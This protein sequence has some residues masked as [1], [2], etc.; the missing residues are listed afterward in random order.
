MNKKEYNEYLET[1]VYRGI[2]SPD[3][4]IYKKLIMR[5]STRHFNPSRRAVFLLR[6]M[7]YYRSRG[8]LWWWYAVYLERKIQR[9]FGCYISSTAIIGKGFHLPH[10]VGVVIGAHVIIEENV[11]VYQGVTIGGARTGDSKKGNHPQVKSGTTIFAGAKVL[12]SII[13][14]P[15]TIV[16]ANA[17]LI[18]NTEVNAVY[19]GVPARRIK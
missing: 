8:G 13:L 12:G 17:V 5:F 19:G 15:D 2:Y 1:E 7:Q 11:S 6:K 10:P 3:T 14:A 16:A 18:K 4:P 9:E